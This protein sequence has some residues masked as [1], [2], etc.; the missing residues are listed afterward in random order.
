MRAGA[1]APCV[2]LGA[3][4]VVGAN[5]SGCARENHGDRRVALSLAVHGVYLG[6]VVQVYDDPEFKKASARCSTTC[7]DNS[8]KLGK[9]RDF[10]YI[11]TNAGRLIDAKGATAR[12]VRLVCNG[13]T[14]D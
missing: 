10:A 1:V 5:R 9:G 7:D 12:Y 2:E 4:H 6:V 13:N 8:S 3:E 14:S 11:E